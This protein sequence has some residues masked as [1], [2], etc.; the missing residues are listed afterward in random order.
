MLFFLFCSAILASYLLD[1]KLNIH[2]KMG[3]VLA[4]LGST[5][6]VLNAPKEASVDTLAEIGHNL[7]NPGKPADVRSRMRPSATNP[8]SPPQSSWP[9][10]LWWL[11]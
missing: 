7:I 8:V 3:V 6:V 10:Q 4:C 2:G 11:D 5:V 9:S 1:E